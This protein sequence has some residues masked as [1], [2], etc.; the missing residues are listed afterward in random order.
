M[1]ARDG[2]R[3]ALGIALALSVVIGGFYLLG[4]GLDAAPQTATSSRSSPTPIDS[5][6]APATPVSRAD[7]QERHNAQKEA[8][9]VAGLWTKAFLNYSWKDGPYALAH[10]VARWSTPSMVRD[11]RS[12]TSSAL[13][14][15]AEMKKRREQA[16]A[17]VVS[18]HN[19]EVSG[20]T[21]IA[22]LVVAR[23]TV[24]TRAGKTVELRSV[25]VRL[26]PDNK[27]WRVAE[28]LTL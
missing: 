5:P 23:Q 3:S 15:R 16:R 14:L 27:G 1:P 17:T 9:S 21:G 22:L 8:R 4:R 7:A 26:V 19:F 6:T 13:S 2:A 12:T 24:T 20:R 11:L 10:R 25:G 28:L 18:I